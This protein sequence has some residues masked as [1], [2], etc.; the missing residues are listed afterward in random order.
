MTIRSLPVTYV[1]IKLIL[2]LSITCC[3]SVVAQGSTLEG[4]FGLQGTYFSNA[5]SEQLGGRTKARLTIRHEVSDMRLKADLF[6]FASKTPWGDGYRID[7]GDFHAT[8][9]G[10]WWTLRVGHQQVPWGRADA[11]RLLDTVNPMRYPD[12]LF[13]E[14]ADAR[15]PLWMVN[16]ES[17]A[18]EWQWQILAGYDRRLNAS[19]PAFPQF[20]KS[21]EFEPR[22]DGAAEFVGARLGTTLGPVDFSLYGLSGPNHQPLWQRQMTGQVEPVFTRRD[23]WGASGDLPI[24]TTVLRGE[25]TQSYTS[26]LNE[27][28]LEVDQ[29]QSQ[30]LIGFDW[31]SG[32]WFFSPQLYW[33]DISPMLYS[34]G[35]KQQTFT[36]FLVQHKSMQDRLKIQGFWLHG[37][38]TDENWWSLRV[39][40]E[41]T[42]NIEWLMSADR[43]IVYEQS[44]LAAFDG[45]N[46]IATEIVLRY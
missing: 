38:D 15:L 11:F 31:E 6:A 45:I 29:R 44:M 27:Q 23:L 17:Q 22:T 8:W 18:D 4:E 25:L 37:M 35:K 26:T 28:F 32:A 41:A 39:S 16:W 40:F 9:F 24:G 14:P 33:Q 46:R 36:S 13:D 1:L 19:D 3:A 34:E 21:R 30:A 43:F 7:L 42:D 2:M 5:P 10:D 12:A 20:R